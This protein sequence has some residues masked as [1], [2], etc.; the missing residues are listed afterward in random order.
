MIQ[1]DEQNN[2]A[3]AIS[4][5]ANE[6]RLRALVTASSDVIYTLSADWDVMYKL[7]GRGFLKNT[8]KP[9]TG[10]RSQNVYA[11]DM[12]RVNAAIDEAIRE[13][14]IFEL[15]HRV[16][17]ADGTPGWTV[18][19]A[20]PILDDEGNI[21]EWFGTASDITARKLAEEK[22]A[23]FNEQLLTANEELAKANAKIALA[24]ESLRIA[25]ESGELGTWYYEKSTGRFESS[26]RFNQIFGLPIDTQ[27]TYEIAFS[28]IRKDYQD[29][30][31]VA[32]EASF[33]YGT[34]FS[35]EYP[36]IA[37]DGKETWVR[38]VGK[39]VTNG[40]GNAYL[41]GVLADIT[42]QKIDDQRKNAF[43]SMVSHELKTPLTS[44]VSY[45]QVAQKK[46]LGSN[47]T[48]IAGMMER[49]GKQ[50]GK[51]TR[52]INGFL[53]VS[54][55]ESGK[56]PIDRQRFDL[57]QLLKET[58]EES[59]AAIDTH[60]VVFVPAQETWIDADRDKIG[61]VINNLLSNSIK[62]SP[63]NS[64]I[65]ISCVTISDRAQVSVQDE[66]MGM[67]NDEL[68]KLFDRYYRTKDT[69]RHHIAGFG[70]GLYLCSEIIKQ[71]EG[72][73]WAESEL[74]KGSTLHFTLP[75]VK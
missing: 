46:A 60:Q 75:I 45:V 44:T 6:K 34:N 1:P 17:R 39:I 20:V 59:I 64:T 15:E 51:M 70:I 67:N 26:N 54:R 30:V 9:M 11:G 62:Y 7:D 35:I 58:E 22:L 33:T 66:G 37:A 41:T 71:H 73:I 2:S 10:W 42:Q 65:T 18:S 63:L 27:C 21:I 52:M 4:V 48:L 57:A 47:D 5:A 55:L 50:L 56:I 19:R 12:D 24:E 43:I 68:P 25:T 14:K 3:T 49:A 69:E 29:D 61:Q 36:V 32:I 53:N 38:S 28:R 40:G 31:V 13:K 8:D 16:N 23:A 72:K 74:Q